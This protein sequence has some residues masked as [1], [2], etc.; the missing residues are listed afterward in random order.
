MAEERGSGSGYMP[1]A[2]TEAG[3]IKLP[4]Q[5][6]IVD[7]LIGE[8]DGKL[9]S[10][11][12][13]LFA[14]TGNHWK[15]LGYDDERALKMSIQT[16]C[17][18]MAD[19][20]LI[21]S[22]YKL[23][24]YQLPSPPEGIDLFAPRP[25]CMNFQNGTMQVIRT[26]VGNYEKIFRPH[27]RN[28]FLINVLPYEY[29]PGDASE[30]GE[31]LGMLDRVFEGDPDK[32]EKIRSVRQMFGACLIPLFPQCFMLYGPPKTGKSTVMMVAARLV[33]KDNLCSVDPTQ[34]DGFN[35]E[36]MAGKLVN[37]DTDIC[38]TKPISD[39]QIK[40][41]ID[42]R[43]FRIRRKGVKDLSAPIP[44]V[45]IFGGNDIPKTLDGVS[46]AHDRRWTFIEFAKFSP[47][48]NY[49]KEYHDFVFESSPQ[50]MLNFALQGL[51][52][53][54]GA[55]GHYTGSASGKAKME[56]WQLRSD[57]VGQ[58]LKDMEEGDIL[59]GT[60]K[61]IVGVEGEIARHNLWEYFKTWRMDQD[62][63]A[64]RIGK[65]QFFGLMRCKK[66][67][68][69]KSDGVW[70]FMGLRIGVPVRAKF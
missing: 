57:P 10:Q 20:K 29:R 3:K 54:L 49:D 9:I 46:R 38:L 44:S 11:E 23:F 33:H 51:D 50:G 58:F 27:N 63:S 26:K 17:R 12:R 66:Y 59:D 35:M 5:Q 67:P 65:K 34:F 48:G 28:D 64:L 60:T 32:D 37:L 36:G 55:R 31:F 56:E 45:H 18:G 47:T 70:Y 25:D 62:G 7:Y 21:D 14:Y 1:M 52:D 24:L 6:K 42:R 16:A 4:T 15:H 43:P 61:L 13:D 30:N 69:K 40:K 39:E 41:I 22:V 2:R 68:E 8:T 53:L 19:V